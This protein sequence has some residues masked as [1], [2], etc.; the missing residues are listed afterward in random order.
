[1]YRCKQIQKS[2]N[3]I[4]LWSLLVGLL[5]AGVNLVVV[6]GNVEQTISFVAMEV[7]V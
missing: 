6:K 3:F 7:L 2:Q 5:G 1:M 4:C